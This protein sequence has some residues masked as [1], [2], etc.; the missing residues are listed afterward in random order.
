MGQYSYFVVQTRHMRNSPDPL[1]I[2]Y[3]TLRKIVGLLGVFLPAVLAV[4][5]MLMRGGWY[6]QPSISD[7]YYTEMRDVFVGM[8]CAVA[9]FLLSYKGYDSRDRNASLFAG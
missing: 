7:Y 2:S 1:L 9:L 6:M 5:N 3:L 4:G 8:L